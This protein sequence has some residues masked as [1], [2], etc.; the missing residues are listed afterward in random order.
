MVLAITVTLP[1]VDSYDASFTMHSDIFSSRLRNHLLKSR[2]RLQDHQVRDAIPGRHECPWYMPSLFLSRLGTVMMLA[3][4]RTQTLV[5]QITIQYLPTFFKDIACRWMS[6]FHISTSRAKNANVLST[7]PPEL[8]VRGSL[9]T[10]DPYR[11]PIQL[12]SKPDAA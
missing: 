12:L 6:D 2:S 5:T 9:K 10:T 8:M 4:Q 3:T 7:R 1:T 11:S